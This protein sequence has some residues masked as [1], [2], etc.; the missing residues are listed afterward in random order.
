MNIGQRAYPEMSA[1][2][3][4]TKEKRGTRIF[5]TVPRTASAWWRPPAPAMK[6]ALVGMRS[7]LRIMATGAHRCSRR[8]GFVD[9][10]ERLIECVRVSLLHE[11][12][13]AIIVFPSLDRI[14]FF[15]EQGVHP[16][17]FPHHGWRDFSVPG[18]KP[19]KPRSI[20]REQHGTVSPS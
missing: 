14:S 3:P 8:R 19:F 5:I 2:I 9:V 4:A 6:C 15:A 11:E 17:G 7:D 18:R 10:E 20:G 12:L 13:D 1:T 16:Q